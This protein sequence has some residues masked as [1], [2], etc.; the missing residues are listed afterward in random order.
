M[1]RLI[2]AAA[3][4]VGL[5]APATAQT[6]LRIGLGAD[7]D[8]LDPT[9]SRTVASRQVF[10]A[11]CD[12]LVDIN[13]KLEIVP[14]LATSWEWSNEGRTLTLKLRSGVIFHDGEKMDAAA[15]KASLDRHLT[16]PGSTR[17]NEMG[18]VKEITAT[19][20]DTVT[21]E[22]NQPFAPLVA[23][24]ADRAGMIMSP[25]AI[26]ALGDKFTNAPVCAGPF[27]FVRRVAQDRVELEKFAGYWDAASIH[28]DRIIYLPISENTV[29]LNNLRANSLD[30]IEAVLPSDVADLKKDTRVKIAKG[31]SLSATYLV[32]NVG[33]GAAAQ[34][35][36]NKN[37]KLRAALD[38]AID[39]EALV[40]VL[41]DGEYVPGNQSVAP[42][43]TFYTKS[44]PVPKRDVAKAKALIKEAGFDRVKV[45]MTVPNSTEF[46]QAAEILQ[47]MLAEANI[48][49][50]LQLVETNTALAEWTAGK[51]ESLIILW[52]GRVDIDANIYAFKACDGALN[53]GKY[54]N[55]E[56]DKALKDGR[57]RV[58]LPARLNAYDAAAKIY[59]E[60]RPYIYLFHRTS[61]FGM[62]AKLDGF[63][64]IPDGL[65]RVQ[66]LKFK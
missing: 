38:W 9:L 21:I 31:A 45:H 59:L 18:P 14:Q 36:I 43:T 33:N 41:S 56:V 27:K 57:G 22:M 48:D 17:R 10:A 37:Q 42:G 4:L 13:E 64:V 19:A 47:G 15:V 49:L 55:Q 39:R 29:R 3:V 65:M 8:T 26:A 58:Y 25:K 23:A 46:K 61:I 16:M 28:F 62:T 34:A 60:E 20:P 2:L 11:L 1:K 40:Q 5:A 63:R 66:G 53:G 24:L 54:C 44:I 12:K 35:P 32:F 7:P 30:L 52:S 6:V 51:F 50:E